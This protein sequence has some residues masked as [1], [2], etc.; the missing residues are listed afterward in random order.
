MNNHYFD[1]D[2]PSVVGD[3]NAITAYEQTNNVCLKAISLVEYE[4]KLRDYKGISSGINPD[5][6]AGIPTIMDYDNGTILMLVRVVRTDESVNAKI[7]EFNEKIA[8][9]EEDIA[10]AQTQTCTTRTEYIADLQ[11]RITALQAEITRTEKMRP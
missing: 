10:W 7:A 1:S 6:P 5:I 3:P 8:K 11:G 9:L 2:Q 4:F